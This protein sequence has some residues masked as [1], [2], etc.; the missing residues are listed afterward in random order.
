[1]RRSLPVLAV[2]LAVLALP[3]CSFAAHRG[4]TT[5]TSSGSSWTSGPAHRGSGVS[6]TET[7]SVAAFRHIEGGDTIHFDV[8]IGTPQ[9]LTLSGDD[10]LLAFVRTEVGDDTLKV[11]MEPGSYEMKSE[12]RLEIVVPSLESCDLGGAGGARIAGLDGGDLRLE[13]SGVRR[14][15]ASGRVNTLAAEASGAAELSAAGVTAQQAS[16][17]VSGTARASCTTARL[18]WATLSGASSASIVGLESGEPRLTLTGTSVLTTAG[19]VES[20][21]ADLSGASQLT[22]GELHAGRARFELSGTSHALIHATE[23]LTADLSGAARL[24]YGGKPARLRTHATGTSSVKAL[25]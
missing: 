1:M 20:L 18:K 13:V 9:A 6:A 15:E 5:T 16:L 2:V 11:T 10:N 24:T 19:K 3:A 12:L 17:E 22:G 23:D 21:D 14:L 7:R 8:R 4:S 25:P